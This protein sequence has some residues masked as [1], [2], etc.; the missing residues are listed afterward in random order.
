MGIAAVDKRSRRSRHARWSALLLATMITA[1]LL[2]GGPAEAT[3]PGINGKIAYANAGIWVAGPGG[4]NPTRLTSSVMD[5][6]PSWSPDGTRIAFTRFNG[7]TS[8]ECVFGDVW[9]MDA[10]GTDQRRVAEGFNPAWSPDGKKLAYESCARSGLYPCDNDKRNVSLVNPDGTGRTDLTTDMQSP[11]NNN[12]PSMEKEPAWSPDGKQ[13]AFVSTE[14]GCAFEI[15]TMNADGTGKIRL[16]T[17]GVNEADESP[18]WSPDGKEIVFSRSYEAKMPQV[19]SVDSD[20]VLGEV[21]YPNAVGRE[22]AWSPDGRSIVYRA[23]PGNALTTV[24]VTGKATT[25]GTTG[26]SPDWYSVPNTRPVISAPKPAPGSTIRD[27]TPT[28]RAL[29]KDRET[30]LAR[31]NIK[32]YVDGRAK[33]FSYSAATDTLTHKSATLAPGRHTVKI[34]ARDAQGLTTTRNWTFRVAR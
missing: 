20:G 10:D 34:V 13:I 12:V 22:P 33:T 29:V 14:Q 28:V 31:S 17:A 16:T 5:G 30:N 32:L 8:P 4:E 6:D 18:S 3:K 15:Y 23:T 27:A 2:G 11:C 21:V 24:D 1:I 26:A 9:V 25:L 7:C 19:H